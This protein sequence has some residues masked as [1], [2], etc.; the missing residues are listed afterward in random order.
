MFSFLPLVSIHTYF[1]DSVKFPDRQTTT[2]LQTAHITC[3]NTV[4]EEIMHYVPLM[5]NLQQTNQSSLTTKLT[6][7]PNNPESA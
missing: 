4:M 7:F 2:H 5:Q 1:H 3:G 6:I